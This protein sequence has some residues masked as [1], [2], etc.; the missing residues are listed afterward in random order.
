MAICANCGNSIPEGAEIGLGRTD[1]SGQPAAVCRDCV[2]KVLKAE[3]EG[4]N[5]VGAIGL[6]ALAGVVS[7]AVWYGVVATT[8]YQL[9][10]VAIAVGWLVSRAVM[11]GA[12]GKR[13]HSLQA[14]AMVC[15]VL[16]MALSEYLIVRH[17]VMLELAREG[18]TLPLLLPIG[19]MA[20]AVIEGVKAD[21]LTLLFWAIA[22]YEGYRLP[23]PR[24][25]KSP[26]PSTPT[27]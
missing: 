20:T 17:F 13:G 27:A 18:K 21:P 9:G 15:I 3:T 19:L 10:I 7:A 5:P 16:T 26:P 22:L 25:L 24:V 11:I 23:A 12:G 1:A 2:A 4:I 8:N 14:I 6:G